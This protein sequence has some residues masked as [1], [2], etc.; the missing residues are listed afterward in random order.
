MTATN[1]AFSRPSSFADRSGPVQLRQ[2]DK[3]N[4]YNF[5]L[6]FDGRVHKLRID[7]TNTVSN[8]SYMPGILARSRHDTTN[9][10]TD[11]RKRIL[12]RQRTQFKDDA[13]RQL[14]PWRDVDNRN[15]ELDLK[16][17]YS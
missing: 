1:S 6:G 3:N 2:F 4:D 16:R 5:T 10:L 17:L 12:L 9:D 8:I 13:F 7:I 11:L 14:V 15:H